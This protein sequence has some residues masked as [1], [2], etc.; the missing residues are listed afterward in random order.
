MDNYLIGL[1]VILCAAGALYAEKAWPKQK[2]SKG[3]KNETN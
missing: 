2:D 3:F 1:I